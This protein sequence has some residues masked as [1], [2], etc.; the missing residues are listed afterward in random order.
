M[1]NQYKVFM[2]QISI[3]PITSTVNLWNKLYFFFSKI[4]VSYHSCQPEDGFVNNG[5]GQLKSSTDYKHNCALSLPTDH[6]GFSQL[7]WLKPLSLLLYICWPPEHCT[8]L[9]AFCSHFEGMTQYK[10]KTPTEFCNESLVKILA[11][12][13]HNNFHCSLWRNVSLNYLRYWSNV[14]KMISTPDRK[15]L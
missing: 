4:S 10:K 7:Q 13:T 12:L 14:W 8:H 6:L 2:L 3:Q 1:K 11:A 15:V 9:F 5:K